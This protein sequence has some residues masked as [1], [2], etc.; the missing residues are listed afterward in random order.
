MCG[1]MRG[2]ELQEEWWAGLL[3]VQLRV[4]GLKRAKASVR[5]A[6][7]HLRE[8][9]RVGPACEITADQIAAWHE[10][11][12]KKKNPKWARDGISND[13]RAALPR[14]LSGLRGLERRESLVES[15][16]ETDLLVLW[17]G[18]YGRTGDLLARCAGRP[19][20]LRALR[21]HVAQR[22][23]LHAWHVRVARLG[24]VSMRSASEMT[25]RLW[26]VRRPPASPS[27]DELYE[28]LNLL[29]NCPLIAARKARASLEMQRRAAEYVMLFTQTRPN[30]RCRTLLFAGS[31]RPSFLACTSLRHAVFSSPHYRRCF[32]ESDADDAGAPSAEAL[33]DWACCMRVLPLAP[34]SPHAQLCR[35][36]V[37]LVPSAQARDL[38][39][40]VP[41]VLDPPLASSALASRKRT[42]P[43][44]ET[45]ISSPGA[46]DK[47]DQ[48]ARKD[49]ADCEGDAGR[50]ANTSLRRI[51]ALL[52]RIPKTKPREQL[53][54]TTW[55][56]AVIK[57]PEYQREGQR[58]VFAPAHRYHAYVLE[59]TLRPD[60]DADPSSVAL[61]RVHFVELLSRGGTAEERRFAR[62]A[63]LRDYHPDKISGS[64]DFAVAV[65]YVQHVFDQTA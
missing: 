43:S 34:T 8:I 63:L 35:A 5:S 32:P 53:W 64:T 47:V 61:A 38:A 13:A 17:R 62:G 30:R 65:N 16:A 60:G 1:S 40:L 37:A 55:G 48:I 28:A 2:W 41:P 33:N 10:Q 31:L 23:G 45:A 24:A 3:A 26:G 49:R 52:A 46:A 6:L 44:I 19:E 14:L 42:R 57:L 20:L 9:R 56:D 50:S 59:A 25:T 58:L 54:R 27:R 4:S 22:G 18:Q 36:I 21:R 29:E 7:D 12:L 15:L 39:L 51:Q 11:N